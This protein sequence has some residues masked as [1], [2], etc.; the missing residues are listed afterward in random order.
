MLIKLKVQEASWLGG[1]RSKLE[2]QQ[3]LLNHKFYQD[4]QNQSL[5]LISWLYFSLLVLFSGRYS[6]RWQNQSPTASTP[7]HHWLFL[8]TEEVLSPESQENLEKALI[9]PVSYLWTNH[10]ATQDRELWLAWPSHM[11]T[12]VSH[13]PAQTTDTRNEEDGL[14]KEKADRQKMSLHTA[15]ISPS[16]WLRSSKHIPPERSEG[17]SPQTS[18]L[19]TIP[20]TS[21]F[22]LLNPSIV[23]TEHLQGN[24][25]LV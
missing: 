21:S 15:H 22:L 14:P 16:H 4:T 9:G 20:N 24:N 10:W 12:Q 3:A 25:P 17:L 19:E 18:L 7:P 8:R 5:F 23:Y 6:Q 11:T 1:S 2:V 13:L